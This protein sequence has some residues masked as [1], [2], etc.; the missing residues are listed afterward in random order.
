MKRSLLIG[1]LLAA[2]GLLRGE[3][4]REPGSG[5]T[6]RWTNIEGV[7]V[8][9]RDTD[10]TRKSTL[11]PMLLVHGWLGSSYD[12]Q[13]L[14]DE[15]PRTRRVIAPDL[16]GCGLSQKTG[17][18]FTPE[19][20]LRVLELLLQS[21]EVPRVI[22][23]GH[24]MGGGIAVNFT[25]RHPQLVERLVL[26]DPDGL[27]GEEGLLGAIRRLDLIVDLGTALNNRLAIG[28]ATRA[29]VFA[30]PSRVTKEY[31]DSV[32]L[33]CL[34]PQG[35][36]AQAQITKRVLGCSPVDELLP[37]LALPTLVLWGEE[38]RVLSPR[39]AKRYVEMIPGAR[40]AMVPS[41]GHMPQIEAAA[42][43]ANEIARFV[44]PG[45]PAGSSR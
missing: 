2:S 18:E 4:V 39:W 37:G 43:V 5:T 11:V 42:L 34:T 10:S 25:A 27:R 20:Y 8:H 28:L 38:D 12:F 21:L 23:V 36:R 41:S 9:F 1:L 29:N 22:L 13:T 3:E 44:E 24:S 19:Y 45:P 33:T 6:D 32:A 14:I 16:P 40:L 17:I 26:I 35:R 7:M 15:L 30:D 31:L